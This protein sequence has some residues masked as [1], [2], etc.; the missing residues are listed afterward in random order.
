MGVDQVEE[1]LDEGH[2]VV[3]LELVDQHQGMILRIGL[4]PL[5]QAL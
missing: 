4:L 2:L 3:F 5:V 1:D